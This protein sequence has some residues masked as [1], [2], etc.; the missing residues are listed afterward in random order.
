MS[1]FSSLI[2]PVPPPTYTMHSFPNELLWIPSNLDY[3][4]CKTGGC[5]P[6]IFLQC[7][8]ARYLV[9]YLH[10]NG[11]DVGLCYQFAQG[12]R[13]VLEVHVLLVEYP[14]YGISP[15]HCSEETLFQ[16]TKTAFRFVSE[17]LH[18][19]QED[20]IIM[21]RSLGAALAIRLASTVTCHGLILVAPFLSLVEAV[22]GFVGGLAK[23]LVQDA[24]SNRSY[25][26]KVKVPVLIIHGEKDRLVPCSHGQG[27]FDL[28]PNQKKMLVTPK[29]MGHN[30]DLLSH[31]DLL[32]RPMLRFFALPD[33]NFDE[34]HVPPQAFD[35]R[36]CLQYHNL[37]ELARDESPLMKPVGDQEPCGVTD[38]PTGPFCLTRH[39]PGSNGDVDILD[40]NA[41]YTVRSRNTPGFVVPGAIASGLEATDD[42]V[43]DSVS[44]T[45][46][47]SAKPSNTTS[48]EADT[49]EDASPPGLGVLDI[50]GGISRFLVMQEGAAGT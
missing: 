22:Q 21:G 34:L 10:S 45:V 16:A 32:I 4:T 23:H 17:V 31:A 44:T 40:P 15:G 48:G 35:K 11:E 28:C 12:L 1:L 50:E 39:P 33:Y 18:W 25:I 41:D 36:L 43:G 46:A 13:M 8:N 9:F 14:G 24:F 19:P 26:C 42:S 6:A 20:V 37:M 27:I 47:S 3:T 49:E 2:F 38:G 5:M 30:T 7:T 29:T